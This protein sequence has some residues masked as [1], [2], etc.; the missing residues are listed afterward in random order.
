MQVFSR[1]IAPF[2]EQYDVWLT[3]TLTRPPPPLG[4][5][6]FDPENRHQST[7]RM[8]QYPRFTSLAN[9][10]GQPAISLPLCWNDEGLPIGIQLMGR[11]ADEATLLRVAAQLEVARPWAHRWPDLG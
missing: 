1:E 7:Q 2:F 9:V 5:F 11:Y 3:P 6:D 10:T 8:E 4:W